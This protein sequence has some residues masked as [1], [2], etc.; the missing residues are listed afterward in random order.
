LKLQSNA[1]QGKRD[2]KRQLES[3]EQVKRRGTLGRLDF[4]F[5]EGRNEG[6]YDDD[7]EH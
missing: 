7:S 4:G 2:S 3:L 5:G 1:H 6:N